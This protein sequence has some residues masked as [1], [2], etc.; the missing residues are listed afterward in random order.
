[1]IIFYFGLKSDSGQFFRCRFIILKWTS[2]VG[3]TVRLINIFLGSEGWVHYEQGG[4][5][6]RHRDIV[7]NF[8]G[9]GQLKLDI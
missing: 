8:S 7:P 9:R 2:L 6:Q 5:W 4:G 1:M 3:H